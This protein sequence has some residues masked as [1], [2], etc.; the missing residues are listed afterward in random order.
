MCLMIVNSQVTLNE[1]TALI[2]QSLNSMSIVF[3]VVRYAMWKKYPKHPRRW[4]PDYMFLATES[5]QRDNDL[6]PI[7]D[8]TLENCKV[9]N[10]ELADWVIIRV[11]GAV[12]DFHA[13]EARYHVNCRQRFYTPGRNLAGWS[14]DN[15]NGDANRKTDET[16]NKVIDEMT[17]NCQHIWTS[18]SLNC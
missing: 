10:D 7:K 15:L 17:R 14:D 4:R 6:I 16:L 12:G 5:K 11:H 13:A 18:I 8:M 3:T 1:C 2:L 9:R